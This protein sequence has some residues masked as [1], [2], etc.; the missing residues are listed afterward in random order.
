[1]TAFN[2]VGAVRKNN[3]DVSP[4]AGR[5]AFQRV[6]LLASAALGLKASHGEV[7]NWRQSSAQLSE[8]LD[9]NRP[10]LDEG[11]RRDQT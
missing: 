4:A 9:A 6:L 11:G 1:M 5:Q 10:D 2:G 7:N 8:M 3:G